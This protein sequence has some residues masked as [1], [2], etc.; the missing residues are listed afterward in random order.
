MTHEKNYRELLVVHHFL[1]NSIFGCS[2][3]GCHLGSI[4]DT[5]LKFLQ[6]ILE[7]INCWKRQKNRFL[8]VSHSYSPLRHTKTCR[9]ILKEKFSL[10]RNFFDQ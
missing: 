2:V 4:R 8:K 3:E 10:F 1:I 5:A 7:S 6:D 9:N